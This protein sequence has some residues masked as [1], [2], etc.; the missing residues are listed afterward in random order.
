MAIDTGKTGVCGPSGV[1]T[2]AREY[3]SFLAWGA[4]GP[5]FQSRRSDQFRSRRSRRASRPTRQ[6]LPLLVALASAAV[7]IPEHA[8]VAGLPETVQL[9]IWQLDPANPWP[10]GDH[11]TARRRHAAG[12]AGRPVWAGSAAQGA[13]GLGRAQRDISRR[14]RVR[15]IRRAAGVVPAVT[16]HTRSHEGSL[17]NPAES[18]TMRG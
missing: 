18:V 7:F 2:Y 5:K 10:A 9:G 15:R 1:P 13:S 12:R 8:F 14:Q 16:S 3:L 17:V 11:G 6:L 4:R